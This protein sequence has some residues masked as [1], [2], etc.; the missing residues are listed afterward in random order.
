MIIQ[1]MLLQLFFAVITIFF[2]GCGKHSSKSDQLNKVYDYRITRRVVHLML[3]AAHL[4]HEKG[5]N[6]FVE[7]QNNPDNWTYQDAYIYVYDTNGV[8]LF[9]GGIPDFEGRALKGI[10]DATGRHMLD[11]AMQ[12]VSN[13]NNLYGWIHYWWII[14]HHLYP[15]W[16]SSCHDIVTMPGGDKVLVGAGMPNLPRERFFV[17]SAVDSAAALIK[18]EGKAALEKIEDP[19]GPYNL[20][21]SS[22]FVVSEAGDTFIAPGFQTTRS[23]CVLDYVDDAGH[24]PLQDAMER[25]KNNESTWVVMI[26]RDRDSMNMKKEGLYVHKTVLDNRIVYVAAT[27]VLPKPAWMN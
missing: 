8:N 4:V 25:L 19:L 9:H 5:T 27:A 3:N 6:A 2:F 24:K 23:R 20:P 16:K 11:L 26:I 7:F 17:K 15:V 12:A 1:K 18:R 21:G 13:T 10:R 22:V 14:P